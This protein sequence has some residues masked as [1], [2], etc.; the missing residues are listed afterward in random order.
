MKTTYLLL[1]I[2]LICS[3]I[4]YS[5]ANARGSAPQAATNAIFIPMVSNGSLSQNSVRINAP[6]F[7]DGAALHFNEAAIFWFGKVSSSENYADLRVA[8]DNTKLWVYLSTFDRYLWYATQPGAS[9]ITTWDSVTLQIN[10]NGNVGSALATSAYRFDG[11]MSWFESRAAYQAAYRGQNSQWAAANLAFQTTAGYDGWFNDN[12][13]GSRGWAIT[14]EIPFSSLGLIGRPADGSLWGISMLMHDRD[15]AAGPALAD[16]TW[17]AAMQPVVPSTWAQLRF[18][19]PPT[20]AQSGTVTGSDLIRR[21]TV[22]G[23]NVTDASVG[24]TTPNLC[25]GDP[26]YIW[27]SWGNTNFGS[28]ADFNIQNQSKITDWPC[29]AKYFV[30]FPLATVPANKKILSARLVLHHQ[31]SAGEAG[32]ATPS[33][34]QVLTIGQDWNENTI[35]WNNA[36][37]P[38]ENV[39]QAWVDVP[40]PPTYDYGAWP[41]IARYWDVTSAVI[42]AYQSNQPVR[43]VLYAADSDYHSGKYFASS[44]TGDW[45]INGRPALEIQWGN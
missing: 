13:K 25:P 45:N 11:A 38:L 26:T 34:I 37:P 22:R 36:P 31:G 27:N 21:D 6:Y 40:P 23:V 10:L 29:F 8:Y 33:L 20:G 2:V 5:P 4:F 19:L 14:F 12:V 44:N 41:K 39:S 42:K 1:T 15:S 17:P 3:F 43:F 16:T 9:P 24:G 35:T 32:L 18:G 28:Q 7:A 30:T